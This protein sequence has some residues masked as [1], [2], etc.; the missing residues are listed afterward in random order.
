MNSAGAAAEFLVDQGGVAFFQKDGA[1]DQT[2]NG[3]GLLEA[4]EVVMTQPH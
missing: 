4:E 3:V 1:D 2:G